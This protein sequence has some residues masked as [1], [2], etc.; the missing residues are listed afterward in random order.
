MVGMVIVASMRTETELI[1]TS[2]THLH[3]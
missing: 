3:T 2:H 1:Y